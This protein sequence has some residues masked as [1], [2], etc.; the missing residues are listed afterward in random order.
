MQA[1]HKGLSSQTI[2]NT[3][4]QLK[5]ISKF[6]PSDTKLKNITEQVYYQL[7][8]SL[9]QEYSGETVHSLDGTFRKLMHIA[10]KQK[11]I[12]DNFLREIDRPNLITSEPKTMKYD[13]FKKIDEYLGSIT[14]NIKVITL[15]RNF[16]SFIIPYIL[17]V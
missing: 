16:N 8:S 6:L 14:K 9:K 3:E 7:T 1:I 10:Y 2:L 11:L 5:A 12:T 4:Q 13:E 17:Q 15:T